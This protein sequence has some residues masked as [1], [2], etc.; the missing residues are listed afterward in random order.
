VSESPHYG[1]NDDRITDA[2]VRAAYE[3][4]KPQWNPPSPDDC[5]KIAW[6]LTLYRRSNSERQERAALKPSLAA[7][8]RWE[9]ADAVRGAVATILSELPAIAD[10]AQKQI[11]PRESAGE[12]LFVDRHGNPMPDHAKAL[13][14]LL[15]ATENAALLWPSLDGRLRRFDPLTE[16]AR[17]AGTFAGQILASWRRANPD[18]TIGKPVAADQPSTRLF[19]ALLGMIGYDVTLE[20]IAKHFSRDPSAFYLIEYDRNA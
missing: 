20:Q 11:L 3:N 19:A 16:W 12:G 6:T 18:R 4:A 9:S 1:R 8:R 15:V 14:D 5:E 7:E 17:T 2:I 10:W 13:A